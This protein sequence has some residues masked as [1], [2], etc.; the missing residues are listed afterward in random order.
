MFTSDHAMMDWEYLEEPI[1]ENESEHENCSSPD[2]EEN[3]HKNLAEE[4]EPND[5]FSESSSSTDYDHLECE[6]IQRQ[7]SLL[8]NMKTETQCIRLRNW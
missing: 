5:E 2:S 4:A 1:N 3:S 8:G 7:H 6:R